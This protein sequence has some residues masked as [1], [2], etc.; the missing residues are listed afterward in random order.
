[1]NHDEIVA[2]YVDAL[3]DAYKRLRMRYR[4]DFRGLGTRYDE[5]LKP[6]ASALDMHK[7]DPYPYMQFIFDALALKHMDVYP[8]MICSLNWINRYLESRPD[9]E[10]EV[11]LLIE[12]QSKVIEARLNSGEDLKDILLDA[13]ADLSVVFR[14]A[15]AHSQG[16]DKLA[17]E[18]E[19]D[20]L[21]MLIFEPLYKKHLWEW[22]PE[23]ARHV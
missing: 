4:T 21:R 7:I 16:E 8:K 19:E 13:R 9:R 20:A 5:A 11:R 14:Y 22:L 15:V 18:F 23:R 10:E 1:M 2:T 6:V 12:L 17:L 3:K